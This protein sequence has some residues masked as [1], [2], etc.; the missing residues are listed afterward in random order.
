MPSAADIAEARRPGC[1]R[2]IL[3]AA[4]CLAVEATNAPARTLHEGVGFT[5]VYSYW[6]RTLPA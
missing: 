2:S 1:A 4:I 3:G 6:Y 5:P